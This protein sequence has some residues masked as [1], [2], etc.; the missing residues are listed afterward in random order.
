MSV[1]RTHNIFPYQKVPNP[2]LKKF[3]LKRIR[4]LYGWLLHEDNAS[5]HTALSVKQFLARKNITVME[6]P[7]YSSELAPSDYFFP[8]VKT[9]LKGT[10]FTSVKRIREKTE[11]LLKGHTKSLFQNHYQQWEQGM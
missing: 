11:S 1:T 3:S 10:H 6:R 5:A 4:E 7:P 8:T 9:R 2:R